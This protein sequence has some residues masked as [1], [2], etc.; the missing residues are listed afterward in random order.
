MKKALKGDFGQIFTS[1]YVIDEAIATA[2]V[3]TKK[4]D[5]AR[6]LGSFIIESPS[7]TKLWVGEVDKATA[8]FGLPRFSTAS[9][10]E[11]ERTIGK[12]KQRGIDEG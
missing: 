8:L 11:I 7:I 3:G 9:L 2:L 10:T 12:T 5:L 1:D 6:D 4:H